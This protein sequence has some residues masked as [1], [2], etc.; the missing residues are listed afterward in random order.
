MVDAFKKAAD[1]AKEKIGGSDKAAKAAEAIGDKVNKATGGKY[2]DKV[3]KG[4]D[5]LRERLE[6]GQQG[7]GPGEGA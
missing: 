7:R 6:K 5:A 1:K 2:A 3:E 4:Q